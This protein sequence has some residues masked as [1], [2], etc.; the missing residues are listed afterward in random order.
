MPSAG[1][2]LWAKGAAGPDPFGAARRKGVDDCSLDQSLRQLKPSERCA[3]ESL[4]GAGRSL[5]EVQDSI[6][7]RIPEEER[8][9]ELGLFPPGGGHGFA[10]VS[11]KQKLEPRKA[12]SVKTVAEA[13]GAE[14]SDAEAADDPQQLLKKFKKEQKKQKKAKKKEKKSKKKEKKKEKKRKKPGS[15]SG[16]S[17]SS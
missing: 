6:D 17:S 13:F 7:Y 2:V 4:R 12:S 11:R 14:S 10:Q 16:S 3:G 15:L 5:R 8:L 1:E 9:P